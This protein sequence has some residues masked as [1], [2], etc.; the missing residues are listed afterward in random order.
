MRVLNVGGTVFQLRFTPD[1]RRL[2]VAKH[3]DSEKVTFEVVSLTDG[4]SIRL[5][6]RKANFRSWWF[7]ADYG[8]AIAV[9][10]SGES[11]YIAW[12]GQLHAFRIK[13]GKAL[14]V[15][16][17]ARAHQVVLSADGNRLL[18][19]YLTRFGRQLTGAT[20]GPK[21]GRVLWHEVVSEEFLHVAGFLP[22]GE[23]FVT[24]EDVVRIRSFETGVELAASRTESRDSDH[25]QVSVDGRCLGGIG[26]GNLYL[27]DL[28]TLDKPRRIAGTSNL[29][30]CMSFAFHPNG[31]TVA[32]II[33]G[34][35]LVKIFDRATLN[36]V[37][38]WKW[39]LGA[40]SS[41]AFS[42]DGLLGAAGSEDGRVV[43]WDVDG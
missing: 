29:G 11:C 31:R 33:G 27:W 15:P 26:Y 38:T 37:E 17:G 40:L 28:T 5:P 35:T 1:N 18:A 14:P 6:V 21:G 2:V 9:H 42:P 10:P 22:D 8:D 23:R 24:M 32:A 19:A 34:R 16:K 7:D 25:A 39:K 4:K 3:F 41:V 43:V 30:N 20:T 13:D 36:R 12:N